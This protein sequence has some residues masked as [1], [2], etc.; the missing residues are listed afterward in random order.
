MTGGSWNVP[1]KKTRRS[2]VVTDETF[3]SF[4]NCKRKAFLR[5]AGIP[6]RRTDIET[7]LLDLGRV[8][9]RQALEAFLA[10]YREQ[11][12]LHDPPCLELAL[13]SPPQIIVNATASVNG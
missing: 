10:P 7:V 6:G 1:I 12:V 11:D 3:V 5:A 8:Y 4:L 2:S 9:R 13:K